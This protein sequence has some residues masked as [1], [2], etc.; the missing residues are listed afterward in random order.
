LQKKLNYRAHKPLPPKFFTTENT[1]VR[2]VVPPYPDT[3]ILPYG[4]GGTSRFKIF[5]LL[6]KNKKYW[7]R[8]GKLVLICKILW[9]LSGVWY[10]LC[11]LIF[12][13]LFSK[14]SNKVFLCR[15]KKS[16]LG[17]SIKIKLSILL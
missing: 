13:I 6:F 17:G 2:S 10:G 5:I 3:V 8:L 9:L 11:F 14:K 4:A 15:K 7:G 1:L 16:R 12:D